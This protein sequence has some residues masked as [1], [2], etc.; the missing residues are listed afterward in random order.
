[1][2]VAEAVA[3]C[4]VGRPS[5]HSIWL[6]PRDIALRIVIAYPDLGLISADGPRAAYLPRTRPDELRIVTA[7]LAGFTTVCAVAVPLFFIGP[8][9]DH[10]RRGHCL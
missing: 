1:M 7:Y 10:L 9:I 5:P 3:T 4:F 8:S 6:L 2:R